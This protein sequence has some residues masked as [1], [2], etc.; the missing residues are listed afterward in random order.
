MR[1]IADLASKEVGGRGNAIAWCFMVVG[2]V[3]TGTM[4]YSLTHEGM[5]SSALWKGWVDFAAFFPVL[6]LEGSAL[7]LVYGRHHWF[8]STEQRELADSAGWI[9]WFVLAATSIVH[10]AFATSEQE[11]IKWAMSIYASYVLP[12]AIVAVPML[13]KKLYDS[14]PDSMMKIAVMEMEAELRSQLVKVQREQNG[15]M[16]DA[17]RE[18][19]HTPQV[20]EARVA[21]FEQAAIEHA[22]EIAGFIDGAEERR[23]LQAGSLPPAGE[24]PRPK[25]SGGVLL[26]PQDFTPEEVAQLERL[27]QG[28]NGSNGVHRN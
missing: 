1:R 9:I 24:R 25:W 22:K 5:S 14:A 17:Y 19:L 16:V 10:F 23:Q 27:R 26:N 7:A 13:W 11:W 3:V 8:R 21:V 4:T 2:V 28:G 12:L 20:E 6:L 18:A 15:L